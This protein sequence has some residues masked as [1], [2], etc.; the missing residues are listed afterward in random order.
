MI[1]NAA[2][3]LLVQRAYSFSLRNTWILFASVAALTIG[4]SYF[5][6]TQTLATEQV[7][8]RTGLRD[9]NKKR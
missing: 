4:L 6:G 3:Q 8:T 1:H 5:V 7:E 9:G 2:Q